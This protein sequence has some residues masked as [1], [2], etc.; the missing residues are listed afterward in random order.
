[1]DAANH[2]VRLVEWQGRRKF[3]VADVTKQSFDTLTPDGSERSGVLVHNQESPAFVLHSP[4]DRRTQSARTDDNGI[5][6]VSLRFLA[7]LIVGINP[8]KTAQN[9]CCQGVELL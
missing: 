4:H 1:M 6:R 3:G 9:R 5:E 8:V 2:R 7:Q